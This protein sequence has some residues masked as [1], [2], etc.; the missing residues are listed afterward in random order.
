MSVVEGPQHDQKQGIVGHEILVDR[1][2]AGRILVPVQQDFL[3]LVPLRIGF[4]IID[5][6]THVRGE[7]LRVQD[8][9]HRFCILVKIRDLMGT[10][11]R[12]PMIGC[13]GLLHDQVI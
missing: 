5:L 11:H 3:I 13:P 9:V 6:L 1:V 10:A 8:L 7:I 2:A 12:I 4:L